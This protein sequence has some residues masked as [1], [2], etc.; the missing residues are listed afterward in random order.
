MNLKSVGLQV[1]STLG[2]IGTPASR[3]ML[4]PRAA[5]PDAEQGLTKEFLE[6]G[7]VANPDIWARYAQVMKAPAN[8]RQMLNTW[9]EMSSWDL[10]AA[11]LQ[12]LCEEAINWD[13]FNPGPIW[14]ESNDREFTA[15]L[16]RMAKRVD[17]ESIAF[18]QAHGIAAL[19]NHFERIHYARGEGVQGLSFI[20]AHQ[21]RRYWLERNRRCIGFMWDQHKPDKESVWAGPDNATPI[22]RVAINK[23][24]HLEELWYPFDILHFR[25]LARNRETEHGE[26]ICAEAEGIYRKLRMGL[27]QMV[28][29]RCQVQPDRYVINI[30]TQEQPPTEQIK[31]VNAWRRSMRSRQSFGQGGGTN[32]SDPTDFRSFYNPLALDTILWVAKPKGFEHSITKLGGT[33]QVPDVYDLELL[34]DLFFSIVGAPKM[35]FGLGSKDGENPPSGRALLASDIRSLR[36]VRSIRRPLLA[37]YLW[38]G[39]FHAVLRGKDPRELTINVK[40]SDIGGLEDQMKLELLNSKAELLASLGGVMEQYN[41]PKDAWI[42]LVFRRYLHLPDE[43]VNTFLTALPSPMQ[44]MEMESIASG[45]FKNVSTRALLDAID[46]QIRN[47][48]RC[49]GLVRQIKQ[50]VEGEEDGLTPLPR[51]ESVEDVLSMGQTLNEEVVKS[52]EDSYRLSLIERNDNAASDAKRKIH[53][54][55]DS[56]MTNGNGS[57]KTVWESTSW[58]KF[59][60]KRTTQ[61]H[62]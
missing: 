37:G 30:D 54:L 46:I 53:F 27:D 16:N 19:G 42:D 49:R 28:V 41:L 1:F 52:P 40:M 32:L 26:P 15:D 25:R 43:V 12:E 22:E 47:N 3:D 48:P 23:N 62:G 10:L 7:T 38:L 17:V 5:T 57:Q 50:L 6:M 8:Y 59:M 9:E 61:L 55:Q 36:K 31:T 56:K 51:Y 13:Q 2:M 44:P 34:T 20:P 60:P 14:Y 29:H 58:R 45:Q 11:V 35:W 24:G 21:I 18:S 39:Y 33:T 4:I